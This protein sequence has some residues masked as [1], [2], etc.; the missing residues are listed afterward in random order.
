MRG[1]RRDAEE[2]LPVSG[3]D[4]ILTRVWEFGETR[5]VQG[6]RRSTRHVRNP[7]FGEV[8][9]QVR[10]ASLNFRDLVLTSGKYSAGARP[11]DRIPLS[12]GAGE[13]IAVGE[14]VHRWR[15]GDRVAATFSLGWLDGDMPRE[16]PGLSLGGPIDGVL[17]EFVTLPEYGLVSIPDHLSFEEAATLPCAA[18]TA[19]NALFGLVP[20]RPGQVVLVLG[21]G[22]VSVFAMQLA[23]IAGA[24]VI[25]TSSSDA[26]LARASAIGATYTIN[27]R[28]HPEW[29][30]EVLRLT[31]GRGVDHVVEV[32]G[33]GTLPQSL[34][35]IRPGGVI[36]LIGILAEG[37]PS[38]PARLL[39]AAG[40][41]RGIQVGSRRM[42]EDL[43]RAISGSG[44]RPVVDRV[45]AFDDAPA[46]LAYLATGSHVGKV[47]IRV[48]D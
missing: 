46:A 20:L 5:S 29:S 12:D 35:S 3:S 44:M 17:S 16:A 33:T 37:E 21:T 27:Y 8:L 48:G 25:A 24:E 13:V 2:E 45:F 47:V 19:W 26:K 7:G 6:W 43:N 1:L 34:D 14:G 40:V 10:A 31:G 36:S 11:P 41:L 22:G 23:R 15:P 9:V 39:R 30:K 28:T 38:P 4:Q 42:F 32:G 18:V